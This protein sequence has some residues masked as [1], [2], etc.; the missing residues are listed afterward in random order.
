MNTDTIERKF[1]KMG[2]KVELFEDRAGRARIQ[3]LRETAKNP[4]AIVRDLTAGVRIPR[5]N[6]SQIPFPPK[7]DLVRKGKDEVFIIDTYDQDINIEVLD[8]KPEARHLLLMLRNNA[9][10]E[11]S[12]YLCGHDERHWFVVAIPE[13]ASAKNVPD[14]MEA[15][16]PEVVKDAL[17]KAKVKTKNRNKRKN[18]AYIRQGEWFFI[19]AK[20]LEVD[21]FLIHKNEPIVRTR[22]GKPHICE[23]V[24]RTG[25]ENVYL[26]GSKTLNEA[27]Y[28]AYQKAHPDENNVTWNRMVRDA[29]V[30]A[31]GYVRHPDHST[32]YLDGWYKVEPNTE[33]KAKARE[34]LAFLD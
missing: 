6:V 9:T 16:K 29:T 30:Y 20:N 13:S 34:F 28:K 33:N 19:P 15:L 17:K 7:I 32:T 2:A 21:K 5:E 1:A 23:F 4:R 22:G 27:E 3:R 8:L 18:D 10:H 31:K 25:G 26:R 11:N 24:Y 14:A 12:K